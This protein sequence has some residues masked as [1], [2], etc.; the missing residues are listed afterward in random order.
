MF[1]RI[2][3][4]F[5]PPNYA[6]QHFPLFLVPI[7]VVPLSNHKESPLSFPVCAS[8]VIASKRSEQADLV[9]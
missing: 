6:S 7:I 3:Y 5:L 1:E 8:Y 9:V 4:R 2:C